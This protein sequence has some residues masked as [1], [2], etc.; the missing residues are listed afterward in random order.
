M[1]TESSAFKA[2]KQ[3]AIKGGLL[4]TAVFGGSSLPGA[5]AATM[6]PWVQPG[7]WASPMLLRLTPSDNTPFR[8]TTHTN[9]PIHAASAAVV[10]LPRCEGGQGEGCEAM[11]E[12][13]D[14]VKQ[15]QQ[16]SKE[17][18]GERKKQRL[19]RYNYQNFKDYFSFRAS[20]SLSTVGCRWGFAWLA[21]CCWAL[22]AAH[23]C[24]WFDARGW[25]D[26]DL[27]MS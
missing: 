24:A 16:R 8:L 11:A 10:N 15:L 17:K 7:A 6:M 5:G 27:W 3:A 2:L 20:L 19:I 9:F 26:V 14:F 21:G 4:A 18:E 23:P 13:S 22:A 12:G 1:L 25:F